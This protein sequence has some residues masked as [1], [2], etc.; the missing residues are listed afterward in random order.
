MPILFT[1]PHCGYKTSVADTFAGQSGPCARCGQTVTVPVSAAELQRPPPLAPA[2][3]AQAAAAA[4][5]AHRK[6]GWKTRLAIG[7]IV[8]APLLLCVLPVVLVVVVPTLGRVQQIQRQG[9]CAANVQRIGQALLAYHDQ[10]GSFPPAYVADPQGKP[11]HS[12][13]VLILPFLGEEEA[14]L[15]AQYDL[16]EP[17][18]GPNNRQLAA[19]MPQ[20][21]RCPE[22]AS[23]P[24][25]HTSYCV[26]RGQG[27]VFDAD[28]TVSRAAITDG[29]EQTILFVE[30]AGAG[31]PWTAPRDRVAGSV[32]LSVAEGPTSAIDGFHEGGAHACLA[33]GTPLWLEEFEDHDR[34]KAMLTIAGGE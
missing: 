22:D 4:A 21:Y 12:W 9:D 1:C 18:D 14:Q 2:I 5:P 27:F 24:A 15:Y 28:K 7:A 29:L 10:Y 23:S 19:R 26:V 30:T 25:D 6:G 11:L 34:V 16:A 13:R 31:V 32:E 20:V 3:A 17:W 33:D 8:V